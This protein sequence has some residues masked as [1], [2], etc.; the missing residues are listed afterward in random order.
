LWLLCSI[1]SDR[2]HTITKMYLKCNCG[3]NNQQCNLKYSVQSCLN[4]GSDWI[5]YQSGEHNE[6]YD[7]NKQ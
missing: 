4:N 1:C 7:D 2:S 5:L 6:F 3:D